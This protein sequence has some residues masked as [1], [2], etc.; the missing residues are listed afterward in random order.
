M[1]WASSAL[2]LAWSVKAS[3]RAKRST[4][5]VPAVD[6]SRPLRRTSR[7]DPVR[8][9]TAPDVQSQLPAQEEILGA[10]GR[11]RP[12]QEQHPPEGVLDEK[13]CDLQ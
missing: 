12:K 7:V 11:G 10:Q 3:F 1:S 4:P 2:A 5:A 9:D 13:T 6:L 8:L